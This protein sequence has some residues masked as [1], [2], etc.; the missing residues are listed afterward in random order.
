MAVKCIL[1]YLRGTRKLG[2]TFSPNK[3]TLV[4]AFSNTDW[5]GCV[6]DRRSTGGFFVGLGLSFV[7]LW[8]TKVFL[9][10]VVTLIRPDL[11][12]SINK[13]WQFLHALT[14]LHW[15]AVKRILRY[16]SG[17]RKLGITFSPDKSTLVNAFSD[18]DWVRCVDD[19]RSTWGFAVYL[20]RN[21]IP[22]IARK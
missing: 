6:D 12:F 16:L 21:L 1:R 15:M 17:T 8:P 14:T 4:N 2:I 11:S 19:R 13:I 3:S 22:W 9:F 5:V 7:N 10:P 20:G 18:T